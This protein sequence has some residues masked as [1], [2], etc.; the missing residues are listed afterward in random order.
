M[1]FFCFGN[2]CAR[3]RYGAHGRVG[4]AG[5][6]VA[7]PLGGAKF[8]SQREAAGSRAPVVA[9][10]RTRALVGAAPMYAAGLSCVALLR[11]CEEICRY[12]NLRDWEVS[13][14][15]EIRTAGR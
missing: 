8:L 9:P 2:R 3:A 13:A 7:E 15:C 6:T 11:N 5:N 1:C 12:W 4:C 14:A 10:E